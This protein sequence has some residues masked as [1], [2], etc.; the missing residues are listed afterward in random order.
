VVW[1]E[2]PRV[3]LWITPSSMPMVASTQTDLRAFGLC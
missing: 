2:N 1:L 3:R